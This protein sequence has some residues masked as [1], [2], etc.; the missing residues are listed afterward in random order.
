MISPTVP[1]AGPFQHSEPHAAYAQWVQITGLD[2]TTPSWEL[3]WD[4]FGAHGLVEDGH[5][6]QR[7]EDLADPELVPGDSVNARRV[8]VALLAGAR[9]AASIA[10][11]EGL[12]APEAPGSGPYPIGPVLSVEIALA[13][14]HDHLPPAFL[15]QPVLEAAEQLVGKMTAMGCAVYGKA[16]YA[17]AHEITA[18][19]A[20][21]DDGEGAAEAAVWPMLIETI[22]TQAIHDEVFAEHILVVLNESHA[23]LRFALLPRKHWLMYHLPPTSGAAT[24]EES[25]G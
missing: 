6:R 21:A 24:T 15:Q 16:S 18:A 14:L 5:I 10:Q 9:Y 7:K 4:A 1:T 22:L 13:L 19:R 3:V 20:P 12:P 8:R 25:Q 11:P 17:L 2:D 23:P